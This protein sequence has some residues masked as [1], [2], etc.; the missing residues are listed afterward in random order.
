MHKPDPSD[1]TSRTPL[2]LPEA[3][4]AHHS[5]VLRGPLQEWK[6]RG[7]VSPAL[8]ITGPEGIGRRAIAYILAQWIFCTENGLRGA[9]SLPSNETERWKPCGS[10]AH[11]RKGLRGQW[12]DFTEIVPEEGA[13]ETLKIDQFRALKTSVGMGA[14]ESPFRIFL[15]PNAEKMTHQAANSLLK[16]LEEPPPS[17][18][19]LLTAADPT[20]LL[21]TIVSR[22]Q[23]LRLRPLSPSVL[24]ELMQSSSVPKDRLEICAQIAQGSLSRALYLASD[25]AWEKRK[26]VFS[27]LTDPASTI[28]ALVDWGSSDTSHLSLLIDQ[29]EQAT[30]DLIRWSLAPSSYSWMNHD[31]RQQLETH[32]RLLSKKRGGVEQARQFW[33]EQAQRLA[34]TRQEAMAPLNR[35]ILLQSL[36]LPWLLSDEKASR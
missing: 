12:V 20:L 34:K 6:A 11:C 16:L 5:P 23:Q 22:C 32:A 33:I 9:R 8:L 29:L 24:R 18:I 31:L 2:P 7:Q 30:T 21:P 15:I 10:C 28:G 3:L 14:H 1:A 17:W 36:L 25:E 4:I 35:K 26:A 13:S 19:F 27:L